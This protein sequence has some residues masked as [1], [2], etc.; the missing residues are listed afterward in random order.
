MKTEFIQP[1]FDGLRF[2]DNTLPVEVARDLAAYET[3]VIEL[4]KHLYLEEHQ[5]RQ[6][7]PKGFSNDFHLHIERIDD[8]SARPLLS[9]VV[10]GVLALTGG[11]N[12]YFE[13]SRDLISECIAAPEGQLPANFPRELLSHFNQI[14]RSLRSDET[15]ELPRAGGAPPAV[16]TPDRRKR[17]VL[18]AEGVYEREVEL[19]GS[20]GEADWE[21]SSFRL[22]LANGNQ[23]VVAMPQSFHG[24]A[25]E[26]GGRPR[27]QVTFKGIAAFDSS[28]TLQKVVAVESLEIQRNYE[29]VKRLD[30]LA[31]LEGG[32][33]DG[34]GVA[35]D[36]NQLAWVSEKIAGHFPE[37]VP[38]P[39]IVPTPQ[40]NILLEWSLP[41]HPSVDIFLNESTAEF[42]SFG[43]NDV[44]V[45]REFSLTDDNAW[46]QFFA[47]LSEQLKEQVA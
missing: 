15:F 20:I 30:E 29:L 25:R 27:H 34:D 28:D 45:E 6:R 10:A 18:A 24:K 43:V 33:L 41:G 16:L 42:H 44:E 1:R 46:E 31:E 22:R 17:L 36:S 38:L 37:R 23:T 47:F 40:G 32:W 39:I 3:L 4:A 7:V 19:V 12:T 14:G 8:G 35:L 26:F 5:D 13:R 9:V 11:E 21:K 2:H